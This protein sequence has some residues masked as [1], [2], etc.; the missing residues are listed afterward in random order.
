MSV[1]RREQNKMGVSE[2]LALWGFPHCCYLRGALLL[3]G[4]SS[5]SGPFGGPSKTPD[6]KH[7]CVPLLLWPSSCG[8]VK[9]AASVVV[10]TAG[11]TL[12]ALRRAVLPGA[13]LGNGAAVGAQH[14][15]HVLWCCCFFPRSEHRCR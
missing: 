6:P 3:N 14:P 13:S 15:A 1:T 8:C 10:I 12:S 5:C 2:S 9:A 4:F 11:T 7:S